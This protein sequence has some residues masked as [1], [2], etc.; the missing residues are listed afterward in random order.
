VT[1]WYFSKLGFTHPAQQLMQDE[2]V[3]YSDLAQFNQLAQ[4]FGFLPLTAA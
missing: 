4:L 2:G 1:R 3:C